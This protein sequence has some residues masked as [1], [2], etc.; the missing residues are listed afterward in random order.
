MTVLFSYAEEKLQIKAMSLYLSID[1]S[2]FESIPMF[3]ENSIWQCEVDLPAGEHLYKF[4]INDE[5]PLCDP[6]NNLLDLD[7]NENLCSLLIMNDSEDIC[8][9]PLQYHVTIEQYRLSANE[10]SQSL[11]AYQDVVDEKISAIIVCRNV[12]GIHLLTAAWYTPNNILYEYSES[13]LCSEKIDE[14]VSTMFWIEKS[15]AQKEPA[16]GLWTFMLFLDGKLLL[17]DKFS[18]P[19]NSSFTNFG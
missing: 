2:A 5:L 13:P 16:L 11:G 7:E 12:S 10:P 4:I 17:S 3:L 8:I 19:S 18:V 14:Q 15:Q 6:Y 9:N 1:H